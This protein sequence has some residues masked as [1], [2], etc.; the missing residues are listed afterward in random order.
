MA[1]E[2]IIAWN[3]TNWLTVILMAAIG[4]FLLGIAL[5]WWSGKSAGGSFFAA[6]RSKAGSVA[7]AG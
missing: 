6:A 5:K 4:F 3:F 7:T 1:E 2:N